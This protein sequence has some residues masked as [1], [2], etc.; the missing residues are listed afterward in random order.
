MLID[1]EHVERFKAIPNLANVCGGIS[2]IMRE[3]FRNSSI[4]RFT[5]RLP[6]GKSILRMSMSKTTALRK[7][8]SSPKSRMN[9]NF[10]VCRE[11]GSCWGRAA[12]AFCFSADR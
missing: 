4:A 2:A 5:D 6:G 3:S 11:V 7:R 10:R 12:G 8:N 9:K 1:E